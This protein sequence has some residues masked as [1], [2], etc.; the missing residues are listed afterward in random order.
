[1]R[2]PFFPVIV[3]AALGAQV[4][5][6]PTAELFTGPVIRVLLQEGAVTEPITFTLHSDAGFVLAETAHADKKKVPLNSTDLTVTVQK[7]KILFVDEHHKKRRFKHTS[8]AIASANEFIRFNDDKTYTG[9]LLFRTTKDKRYQLINWVDL[10]DYVYA[11]L[12]KESYQTWPQRMQEIQAIASR[13]FGAYHM[14]RA[15]KLKQ[16]FDVRN[17]NLYQ[18]YNG[19]HEFEHLW[20]AIRTT[21]STILAYRGAPALTMY[22]ACCGGCIPTQLASFNFS[23]EPYL[24]RKY[25]CHY[26]K[27]YKLYRWEKTFKLQDIADRLRSNPSTKNLVAKSK[28]GKIRRISVPDDML[29]KAGVGHSILVEGTKDNATIQ[30]VQFYDIVRDK[31]KSRAFTVTT[32]IS[33]K[34]MRL[35]LN[36]RGFGHLAGMC[37]RGAREMVSQ[38]W[39]AR[40][41]LSFYY[42]GT[43]LVRLTG[44]GKELEGC[45]LTEGI[46]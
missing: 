18:V 3:L 13:T 28:I 27:N 43:R 34:G 41:V 4:V 17:T 25:P 42:P 35:V 2:Y 9:F 45:R 44:E 22:D 30:G 12:R 32:K 8:M 6:C 15:R 16:P 39:N 37:Q 7:D 36:G 40:Q 29:D 19:M 10:E 26:C 1:M 31:A 21:R 24:Q 46:W 38:G 23:N 14:D 33:K 20:E 5:A 11:V